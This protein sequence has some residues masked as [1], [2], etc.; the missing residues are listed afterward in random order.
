MYNVR[1][2]P[3]E[4]DAILTGHE[5]VRRWDID[6]DIVQVFHLVLETRHD[7]LVIDDFLCAKFAQERRHVLDVLLFL[8]QSRLDDA[9]DELASSAGRQGLRERTQ[10]RSVP[11]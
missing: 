6:A 9:A 8:V 5:R 11:S 10:D 4:R 3:Q 7:R 1:R 2:Q